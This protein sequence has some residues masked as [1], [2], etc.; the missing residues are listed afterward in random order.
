M[1]Y[2]FEAQINDFANS[3]YLHI[4]DA[5]CEYK[6]ELAR[7]FVTNSD[8]NQNDTIPY[9]KDE[10]VSITFSNEIDA[11]N[12]HILFDKLGNRVFFRN[13]KTNIVQEFD[14]SSL[15]FLKNIG[16]VY[17]IYDLYKKL[18]K[19]EIDLDDE[20]ALNLPSSSSSS[21]FK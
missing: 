3:W 5:N 2:S 10:F 11:P 21:N 4:N 13:V 15:S 20:F 18:Y 14:I 6:I 16:R 8:N 12:D 9:Q 1:D 19:G 17:S 7:K